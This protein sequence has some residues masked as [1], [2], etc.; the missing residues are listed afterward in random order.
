MKPRTVIM[1]IVLPP[2]SAA[3][4]VQLVQLLREILAIVEHQYVPQIHRHQ[5]RGEARP[6]LHSHPPPDHE[7]PF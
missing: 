1:P 3:A 2:L 4:A 5:A 6:R 7:D